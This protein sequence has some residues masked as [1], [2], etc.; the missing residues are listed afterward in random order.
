MVLAHLA[1]LTGLLLLCQAQDYCGEVENVALRGTATQS[2][3]HPGHWGTFSYAANAIDGNRNSNCVH[4]SCSHS[5]EH[6]SPWWRVDLLEKYKVH[7]VVIT[8][9]GDCCTES[10]N[11]A[12]IRIGNSLENEGN[13]NPR[14]ATITSIPA[15]V[16]FSYNCHEM[17]GRYVNVYIPKRKS[18]LVLAEV[19]VYAVPVKPHCKSYA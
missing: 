2:Q 7:Q 12:E 1:L 15:R 18:L 14:C 3:M 5:N 13:S 8:G 6:D 10:I 17:E 9:R 19:E 4:G 11:G 16:S